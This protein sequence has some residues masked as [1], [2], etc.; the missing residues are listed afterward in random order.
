MGFANFARVMGFAVALAARGA[1]DAIVAGAPFGVAF[2]ALAGFG[3]VAKEPVVFTA[4]AAV[5]AVLPAFTDFSGCADFAGM[6]LFVA[7]AFFAG[8]AGCAAFVGFADFA[9]L[10]GFT[11]LAA[12][13]FAV[14]FAALAEG[15]IFVAWVGFVVAVAFDALADFFATVF[16]AVCFAATGLPACAAA[17]LIAV[18]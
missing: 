17:G 15:A 11:V 4:G 9:A 7:A 1:F 13:V 10:V 12:V 14:T 2:A 18:G 3:V 8:A 16:V 6:A 5:L